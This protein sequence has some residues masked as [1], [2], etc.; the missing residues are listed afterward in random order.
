[1][2]GNVWEWCIGGQ[3]WG[4]TYDS[5]PVDGKPTG[6]RKNQRRYVTAASAF[7]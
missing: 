5:L 2:L 6:G 3:V 1:M 4:G 7:G